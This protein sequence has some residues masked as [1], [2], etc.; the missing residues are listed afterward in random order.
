MSLGLGR[1]TS[2]RSPTT[3]IDGS[4]W[5]ACNHDSAGLTSKREKRTHSE[6]EEVEARVDGNDRDLGSGVIV[7]NAVE[8]LEERTCGRSD[9]SRVDGRVRDVDDED[10]DGR[11]R[12]SDLRQSRASARVPSSLRDRTHHVLG[13]R[14][15]FDHGTVELGTLV[16][17]CRL[18]LFLIPVEELRDFVREVAHAA[19][20]ALTALDEG[21]VG[22][23][24]GTAASAACDDS[25]GDDGDFSLRM[26]TSAGAASVSKK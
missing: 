4:V 1:K 19:L 25:V 7:G 22:V 15:E 17:I 5:P 3:S 26:Q 14:D 16:P 13:R 20:P 23:D 12:R 2:S 9:H 10:V 24:V 21:H 8:R 18:T 6:G 11:L